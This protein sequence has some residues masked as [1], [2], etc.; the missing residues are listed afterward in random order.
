MVDRV[1]SADDVVVAGDLHGNMPNLRRILQWADLSSHP[2]RHLVLQEFVHGSRK[3]PDGSD[4]SHQAL[5][6]ACALKCQFPDR[7]HLLLG[8]HEL[9]E[10]TGR[11]IG[12]AGIEL[13]DRF[14]AGVLFAYGAKAEQVLAAYDEVFSAMPLAVR[15]PHR[16][17]V[18]H[19]IPPLSQ[20]D[21]FDAGVFA[22]RVIPEDARGR[23]SSVHLLVWGRDVREEAATAFCKLVDADLLI[24]GHIPSED[25][26]ATPNRRQLILDCSA[27]PAAIVVVPAREATTLDRLLEGLIL[28][29]TT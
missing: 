5:D 28:L 20:L 27:S 18:C 1:E 3:Y 12:K 13:N 10:W 26:Y 8:N 25:G 15:L 2:R 11:S 22:E 14:R 7:V 19:S 16:I 9:S 6:I 21:R 17:F 23:G 24:T 29:D 4:N